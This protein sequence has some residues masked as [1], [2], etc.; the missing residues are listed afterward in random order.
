M[1]DAFLKFIDKK[2]L[3]KSTNKIL[4]AVSGG[5]DSM[6][7]LHLLQACRYVPSVAHA[8]F[9]LRGTESD[10]D[11]SFIRA[12]CTAHRLDFYSKRFETNNYAAASG[13]SIQM[14]AREMRY[15]WFGELVRLHSFDAL[16][17]A[18]HANDNVETVLLNIIK[19][20]GIEGMTGIEVKHDYL[21]R[22]LLF[23]TREQIENYAASHAI[24]WR[25]DTSNNTDDYQR[26]FLR[27]RIIPKLREINPSLESAI[28]RSISKTAGVERFA[29]LGLDR[30]QQ[31]FVTQTGSTIEILKSGV[32]QLGENGLSFYL[33]QF[34]FKLEQSLSVFQCLDLQSGKRFSAKDWDL[35]VDRHSIILFQSKVFEEIIISQA[36]QEYTLG[37]Q[38]LR[39]DF[40]HLPQVSKDKNVATLDADRVNLPLVWRP[41]KEGDAFHP[42]GMPH[43]K[44]LSDFFIDAKFSLAAKANATVLESQGSIIWVVGAR[45]DDRYKIT[46]KTKRTIILDCRF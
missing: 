20:A 24:K 26:N 28:E 7:L 4:V 45:I 38:R 3:C 12:Y 19:G 22:P 34:G 43:R 13:V 16:A 46:P 27:H 17:T 25:E 2:K 8:N 30:W 5:L 29:R 14:A 11:E 1:Q 31:E 39:V 21:I 44:K 9:Q 42:L 15:L 18:H 40:S 35:A 41:W 6:V 36:E 32:A 33:K 37:G 10:G 23:A